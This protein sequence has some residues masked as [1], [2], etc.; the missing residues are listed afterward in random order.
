MGMQSIISFQGEERACMRG[1]QW[2]DG[3]RVR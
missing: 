3:Y 1:E 2:K